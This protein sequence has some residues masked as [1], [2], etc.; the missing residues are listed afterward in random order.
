[1][2][3]LSTF[4]RDFLKTALFSLLFLFT[5]SIVG[6][7][8]ILK[9]SYNSRTIT[10]VFAKDAVTPREM[11]ERAKYHPYMEGEIVVALE[12][13]EPRATARQ[14]IR[15]YEWSGLFGDH[16]VQP[17]AYLMT[18]ELRS[19]R[20]V[21]LVHLSLPEG[22]DVFDAME[23]L[24]GQG[25]VLWSSPNFYFEGDPREVIPN[26][27]GYGSQYH[28]PLMKNNLA[29]DI[30][31]GNPD[32]IIAITDDGVELNH[33]DLTTNIWVNPGEIPG[34]GIDDDGNG[35]IDD[36]NG[37]DFSSGNNNP[38]PNS[39]GNDHGTHVAGIVAARTNNGIGVAGV[40]GHS[41]IM[42][43][44]FYG[45]GPWTA[46][47]CNASFTY[48]T[49]NG[50]N[51]VNT[52]YNIDGFA[53]DP[54][55]TAGMQYMHDAG[56]LHFNSAGNNNQLNPARQAFHQTLL[57]VSTDA[58]DVRS[59]FTNYGTGM[60][61]SAPG[62]S[63]YSTVTLNGYGTKSGTSM[64][65]P[66][67]AG[68][69][70]LI[71]SA[72]P[73]WNSYQVAAQLLATADNIDAVN[74]AFAG[75]MGA[76]RANTYA[77]LTTVIGPPVVKSLTGMPAEGSTVTPDDVT[78]FTI[79]FSQVMDPNTVNNLAYY[80]LR[81]A[82]PDNIFGTGDDVFYTITTS[83]TYMLGTNSMT[84]NIGGP[85]FI[86][87]LHRLQLVSG[88][89]ANPFGTAL[90]GDGNGTGGDHF[91]RNF[92]IGIPP[93]V[94]NFTVSNATPVPGATVVFTDL[95]S[96]GPSA[97]TWTI[98][99]TTFS[100]VNGTNANS[101]NPEVQFA[102]LGAYS[103]TLDVSNVA[104]S[105][106]ETKPDYINVINCVY[107]TA[108][109]STGNEEWISNVTFNTINNSSGPGAGYTDYTAISSEVDPGS[110]HVISV[111]CGSIGAWTE[112]Y[113]VFFDWNQ[114]CDFNDPGESYDLGQTTGPGTLTANVT[115]PVDA[116]AGPVRMRVMLKFSANPTPCEIFNYGE[117]E[118]YTVMVSGGEIRLNLT[119]MLEG[120]FDGIDMH[121]DLNP[122][123]P[124]SQPFN[125]APWNYP[126]AESV[127]AMP[128]ADIVDW[129]LVELRDATSPAAATSG[130][131][132]GRQA[133]FM[134]K[135]G[136]IVGLDGSSNL[137][138][139]VSI[140]QN[141]YAVVWQRNHIGIISNNAL[142]PSGG[143]YSYNYSSG[144]NQVYGGVNGHKELAPGV[145]GMFSGDGDGDGIIGSGDKSPIWDSQAGA[146]GYIISDYNL[147]AE[148]NN[149]DKTEFWI[150]NIG[151]GS[152][153]PN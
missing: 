5:T 123:L 114:D 138:Y 146:S 132:V 46:A 34:N 129:V 49:D 31:Y 44:Q 125:M 64:A 1:M 75:L 110:V 101:Q 35:F 9:Q 150:P 70:A 66:N 80:E 126:G 104:G 16:Q 82:G 89:L 79:S 134:L 56:V 118:D 30:T 39:S 74:P 83:A 109:G 69:A 130:T 60:D 21:S 96:G 139:P 135:D 32:I 11:T 76:G 81:G 93:P 112:H 43:I 41:T 116:V 73:T 29:W 137:T 52:S 127:A 68:A 133:A 37:W 97:W 12:L 153:V 53:G 36:V 91:F 45:V 84:F 28:H 105:D 8:R 2:K 85:P 102:E 122:I 24:D 51:I 151:K 71:W 57:T 33:S 103:V 113:W 111:S 121:T 6:Q 23:L 10:D 143:V 54:V 63:V 98:T 48:A 13:N 136:T 141:L 128:S 19:D 65:A 88:G 18:K 72:N 108:G 95:S 78:Q 144:V 131:S 120:A 142:T 42:P 117:V 92:N 15:Q 119:A 20:S 58:S 107:C 62:S 94:A 148:S 140:S 77:A 17:L 86:N 38:N 22:L 90:D 59:S 67:A 61:I 106:S 7:E 14:L 147:D 3:Q 99:P 40:S 55:F 27:P 50:A 100:F 152:Q 87:G 25:D 149:I 4:T 124:L 26:D 115:V 47:V 145:W